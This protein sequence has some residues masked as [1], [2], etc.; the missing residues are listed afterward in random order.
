MKIKPLFIQVDVP[1]SAVSQS[2]V[3]DPLRRSLSQAPADETGDS[4]FGSSGSYHHVK[5]SLLPRRESVARM[6]YNWIAKVGVHSLAA[7][8]RNAH[9]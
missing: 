8:L 2:P 1:D 3:A 7:C 6:A 9:F 4:V 5:P